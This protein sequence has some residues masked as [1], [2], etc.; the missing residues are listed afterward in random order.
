MEITKSINVLGEVLKPCSKSPLTGFYRDG[1][2]NTGKDD[3]GCHT[4]C[5]VLTSTFL[6]FSKLRGNDLITPRPEYNF[7]GLK[8][9]DRWCLCAE[10]WKEAHSYDSAPNVILESTHLRTLDTIPI[11]DLQEKAFDIN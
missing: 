3:H 9:G 5:V 8:P 4:V 10:R 2:C 1:C 7:P 6:N 11:K